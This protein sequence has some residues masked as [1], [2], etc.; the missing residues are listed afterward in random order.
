VALKRR[1]VNY[2][3]LDIDKME[4][5]ARHDGTDTADQFRIAVRQYLHRRKKSVYPIRGENPLEDPGVTPSQP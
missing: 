1:A 4:F 3:Q 2:E 5:L